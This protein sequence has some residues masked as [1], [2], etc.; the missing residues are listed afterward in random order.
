MG[1]V[2]RKYNGYLTGRLRDTKHMSIHKLS[3]EERSANMRVDN[4][5][6]ADLII[7]YSFLLK[8]FAYHNKRMYACIDSNRT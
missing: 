8:R 4:V 6:I 3:E 7:I 2:Y 5:C 1:F